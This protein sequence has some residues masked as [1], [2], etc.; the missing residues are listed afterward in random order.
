MSGNRAWGGQSIVAPL[1]RV[2]LIRP[3]NRVE[4][5]AWRA[6]GY[7]HPVNLDLAKS[8]HEA[9]CQLL[10]QAGVELLIFESAHQGLQDAIFPF[11]PVLITNAGAILLRMGKTLCQPEVTQME[12]ILQQLA[13]PIIGRIEYPGT[14]E[15]GDCL[16]LDEQT[17]VVGQSYRTN[18][19]GIQQLRDLLTSLSIDVLPMDLPHWHGPDECLHLLSLISLVDDNLAVVS[20]S[21]LP[22]RLIRLLEYCNVELI[23]VPDEEF[24]TQAPNVLALAPRQSL[25]LRENV[26]TIK[27]LQ[28]AGCTVLTYAGDEISQNRAGGPTCLTLPLLRDAAGVK[29]TENATN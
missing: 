21:L 16:W 6:F 11:H 1:R 19:H 24:A 20:F 7:H 2:Q 4:P 26:K 18:E 13:I 28:A 12:Q 25:I 22:V 29:D 15:G 8:E 17:L 27:A 5:E 23:P 14:V 10:E 3:P 9:L